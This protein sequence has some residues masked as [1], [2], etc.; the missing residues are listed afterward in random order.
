MAVTLKWLNRKKGLSAVLDINFN[1]YRKQESLK[2]Y[3]KKSDNG[4]KKK[5]KREQ[6]KAIRSKRELELAANDYDYKPK[7]KGNASFTVYF[8]TFKDNYSNAD[9]RK[10]DSCYNHFEKFLKKTSPAYKK[11]KSIT[12]KKVNPILCKDFKEYLTDNVKSTS[13]VTAYYKKFKLVLKQAVIEEIITKN[14][15]QHIKLKKDSEDRVLKEVLTTDELQLLAK[16]HCGNN[17]VKNAFLLSCF[18]GMGMA[19]IKKLT[20]QDVKNGRLKI[21]R[22]KTKKSSKS[23]IEIRLS[24]TALAVINKYP[25]GKP[26]DLVFPTFKTGINKVIKNWVKRAK[27][28]KKITFYCGRHTFGTMQLL[29]GASLK[30]VSDNMGHADIKQ[31]VKYLNYIDELKDNAIDNLP[32]IE[33]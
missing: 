3:I 16:T 22:Q 14:P 21:M 27:I 5:E 33:L 13:T 6:A 31:T 25:Q 15:A 12:F 26:T 1:G 24:P 23:Y 17:N 30:A 29:N 9:Y 32:D 10:V 7:F 4:D 8:E 2:I 28:D 18:S 19:E 20:W 11:D